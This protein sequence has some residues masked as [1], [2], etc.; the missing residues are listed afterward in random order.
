[1]PLQHAEIAST[2]RRNQVRPAGFEPATRCLEGTSCYPRCYLVK[3]LTAKCFRA[4]EM[5]ASSVSIEFEAAFLALTGRSVPVRMLQ[6]AVVLGGKPGDGIPLPVPRTN[7]LVISVSSGLEES[8]QRVDVQLGAGEEL[9]VSI[10]GPSVELR[11]ISG[12]GMVLRRAQ[13]GRI[14]VEGRDRG[15]GVCGCRA[16]G[17][18]PSAR[19]SRTRLLGAVQGELQRAVF[20]PER[21]TCAGSAAQF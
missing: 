20:A 15:R 6:G 9:R 10:T 1:M 18:H 21:M 13:I 4:Y 7:P 12:G 11:T 3:Y 14:I 19:I 16:R 17:T 8:P 2:L 5:L